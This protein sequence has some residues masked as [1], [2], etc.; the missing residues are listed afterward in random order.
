MDMVNT[1]TDVVEDE[2]PGMA[3]RLVRVHLL[4]SER[5]YGLVLERT[6]RLL[7]EVRAQVEEHYVLPRSVEIH[8][9]GRWFGARRRGA[10]EAR[11]ERLNPPAWLVAR[12]T[13][14][15]LESPRRP[16][17]HPM[18]DGAQ[19]HVYLEVR[20]GLSDEHGTDVAWGAMLAEAL[21][22]AA[23]M[24]DPRRARH[25]GPWWA[26]VRSR[27]ADAARL[28]L[29][30]ARHQIEQEAGREAA[31]IWR[32]RRAWGDDVAGRARR[33][34]DALETGVI[35][36]DQLPTPQADSGQA[37]LPAAAEMA[38]AQAVIRRVYDECEPEHVPSDDIRGLR[39]QMGKLSLTGDMLPPGERVPAFRLHLL[40]C[41]A[42]ADLV[43]LLAEIEGR[44]DAPA[45]RDAAVDLGWS[46][47][48]FDIRYSQ[49]LGEVPA[50]HLEWEESG[51]ARLYTRQE[52]A[53][54]RASLK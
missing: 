52:W 49:S 17:V 7:P 26:P 51:R 45:L 35:E 5:R 23:L 19:V 24:G 1:N 16:W 25:L 6:L 27:L 15:A 14:D 29:L 53:A 20:R 39:G 37:P 4:A 48:D 10:F 13:L 33:L 41:A 32:S 46:L 21:T 54:H 12:R 30:L 9:T 36:A 28:D 43:A 38:A 40:R 3:E 22:V 42:W 11:Q 47:R 44:E 8:L 31:E 50:R 34:L 2:D 18:A